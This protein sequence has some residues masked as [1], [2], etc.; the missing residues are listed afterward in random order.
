MTLPIIGLGRH[1]RWTISRLQVQVS[2][3]QHQP[4]GVIRTEVEVIPN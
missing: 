3:Q 2:G 4:G 1:D